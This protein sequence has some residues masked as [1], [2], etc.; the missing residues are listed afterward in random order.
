MD[1]DEALKVLG[2]L[3]RDATP[4]QIKSAYRQQARKWHGDLNHG[5][6]DATAMMQRVNEAY[7]V[8]KGYRPHPGASVQ[9]PEPREDTGTT[10][11][12]ADVTTADAKVDLW[13]GY[14]NCPGCGHRVFANGKEGLVLHMWESDGR[15]AHNCV[16]QGP[17][18]ARKRR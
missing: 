12:A 5:A 18:K 8:L 3:P 11:Y 9:A 15:T 6:K 7:S 10:A 13:S 16:T 17:P 2:G 1:E 14:I 4:D